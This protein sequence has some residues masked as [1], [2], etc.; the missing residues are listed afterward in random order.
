MIIEKFNIKPSTGW[1]SQKRNRNT[2]QQF[3]SLYLTDPDFQFNSYEDFRSKSE[4][5][6]AIK[7]GLLFPIID[8]K[9]VN[10]NND[11]AL[12]DTGDDEIA[13]KIRNGR[14]IYTILLLKDFNYHKLIRNFSEQ[15]LNVIFV[16]TSDQVIAYN[17]ESE[18]VRGFDVNL[19]NFE[20]IDMGDSKVKYSPVYIEL[21]DSAQLNDFGIVEKL[22]FE[23]S[24]ISLSQVEIYN[25]SGDSTEIMFNVRDSVY[26]VDISGLDEIQLIDSGFVAPMIIK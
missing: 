16:D 4:W 8:I 21:S 7:G 3:K 24:E 5:E 13:T 10:P 2:I 1:P 26:G 17:P 19:V 15:D 20:D 14:Y 11:E 9:N 12:Y 22:E 23:V 25:I 6:Q 18:I